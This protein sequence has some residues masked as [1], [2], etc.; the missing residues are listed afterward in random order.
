MRTV[1]HL[2]DIV[3]RRNTGFELNIPKIKAYPGA[4]IGI[5]GPNGSGKTTLLKLLAGIDLPDSGQVCIDEVPIHH[6]LLPMQASIGFIPDDEEWLIPELTAREY[7]RLLAQVYS[8]G[9]DAHSSSDEAQ[10]LA[11]ILQFTQFEQPLSSLSHG[12]KRKVQLIAGMMHHP[13]LLII[14][15][16]RN[17][18]D[19]VAVI[20]AEKIM[21]EK[22]LAG[23][24]IIAATH[25]LWWTQRMSSETILLMDGTIVVHE[26]TEV[27]MQRYENLE[28]L[29]MEAVGIA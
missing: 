21:K 10:R 6:R 25:D 18:L 9:L 28:S 11:S 8:Q 3:L 22:A 12:N 24:T 27:L 20:R 29:F 14:D 19:P 2:T 5:T 7:F 1:V 4:I 16:L 26:Q 17:G 23:T 15:E 13:K